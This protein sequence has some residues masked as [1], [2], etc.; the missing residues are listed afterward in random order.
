[1][2]LGISLAV[3]FVIT[4]LPLAPG[5]VWGEDRVNGSE[6]APTA[7]PGVEN[8]GPEASEGPDFV[9]LFG[10]EPRFPRWTFFSVGFHHMELTGVGERL[11][12]IVRGDTEELGLVLGYTEKFDRHYCLDGSL[13]VTRLGDLILASLLAG[14][15]YDL[16]PF[17]KTLLTPWGGLYLSLNFLDDRSNLAPGEYE[18]EDWDGLGLGVAA[19]AGLSVRLGG[20]FIL[21]LSARRHRFAAIAMLEDMSAVAGRLTATEYSLMIVLVADLQEHEEMGFE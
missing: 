8:S 15:R 17:P 6:D 4:V 12:G 20:D 10:D 3:V 5:E 13:S 16:S 18:D 2:R 21:Q 11:D 14:V 9:D 19:A 7:P 1:M